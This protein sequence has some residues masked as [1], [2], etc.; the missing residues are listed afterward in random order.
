MMGK[1][2]TIIKN[3]SNA[4]KR[5]NEAV[6]APATRLNKDATIQRFEFCFELGWKAAQ[7]FLKDQ[8]IACKSPKDCFRRAADYGL[9]KSPE[10][11]FKF[12][13]ERNLVSHTYSEKI[14]N[15]VYKK[16]TTFP[17]YARSL[18]KELEAGK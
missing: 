11:W 8:G 1:K 4:V 9:I 6:E 10:P 12:L 15:K 3:F 2:D 13:E 5:L 7:A 18:L 16:A 14:A 17:K